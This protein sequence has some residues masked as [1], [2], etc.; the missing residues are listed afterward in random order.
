MLK[1]GF[2]QKGSPKICR[3]T[4]AVCTIHPVGYERGKHGIFKLINPNYANQNQP[5]IKNAQVLA[6]DTLNGTYLLV[7]IGNTKILCIYY[8]PAGPT[9]IN[10]WLDEVLIACR[11][12][13]LDDL[14]VLGDFNSRLTEWI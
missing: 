1:H 14:I 4:S 10:T 5:A 8:P 6:R 7:K 9:E 2:T 12:T 11:L 13:C 3:E